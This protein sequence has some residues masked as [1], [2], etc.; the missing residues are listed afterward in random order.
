M[1]TCEPPAHELDLTVAN[2]LPLPFPRPQP[3]PLRLRLR[4]CGGI[5]TPI[6]TIAPHSDGMTTAP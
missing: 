5:L 1:A 4:E 2:A 3:L 6:A